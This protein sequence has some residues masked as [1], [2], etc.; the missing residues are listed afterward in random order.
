[1]VIPQ[2]KRVIT[3]GGVSR[4]VARVSLIWRAHFFA[5]YKSTSRGE[6][7]C[8]WKLPCWVCFRGKTPSLSAPLILQHFKGR[9]RL[10]NSFFNPMASEGHS[11]QEQEA[12]FRCQVLSFCR[13]LHRCQIHYDISPKAERW[14][15]FSTKYKSQKPHID[16]ILLSPPIHFPNLRILNSV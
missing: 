4:K 15:W 6:I 3:P 2:E 13:F 14:E 5:V 11:F 7:S 8:H 10:L 1:M 16:C 12:E 9:W